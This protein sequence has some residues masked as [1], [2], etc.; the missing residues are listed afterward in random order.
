MLL[1]SRAKRMQGSRR[2]LRSNSRQPGTHTDVYAGRAFINALQVLLDPHQKVAHVECGQL[3]DEPVR[4]GDIEC[5]RVEHIG[6]LAQA[7]LQQLARAQ[8]TDQYI[9]KRVH[10]I[11]GASLSEAR[12]GELSTV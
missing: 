1:G 4:Y 2:T 7:L 11:V 3:G 6:R 5:A 10:A 8:D 12:K 9:T